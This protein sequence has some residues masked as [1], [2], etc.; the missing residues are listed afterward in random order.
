MSDK[1]IAA[2]KEVRAAEAQLRQALDRVAALENGP[3]LIDRKDQT[4]INE[5]VGAIARGEAVVTDLS[6]KRRELR[7]D[8]VASDD[9]AGI[10]KHFEQ[11][12]DG[13]MVV[14]SPFA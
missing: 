5:N 13:R 14:V 6:V 1:K 2:V 3:R 8:E 9:Q 4:A 12:R 11:I 10:Q 7:P